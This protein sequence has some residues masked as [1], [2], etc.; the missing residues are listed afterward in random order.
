MY[1]LKNYSRDPT[2]SPMAQSVSFLQIPT[3]Y[4]TSTSNWP[5]IIALTSSHI[6]LYPFSPSSHILMFFEQ[7][8]HTLASRPLEMPSPPTPAPP[9]PPQL[10][11]LIGL[12]S[13][14]P[15]EP[16]SVRPSCPTLV[17]LYLTNLLYFFQ[18]TLSFSLRGGGEELD[19]SLARPYTHCW[20][21]KYL[22][23]VHTKNC[24][25]YSPIRTLFFFSQVPLSLLLDT[26]IWVLIASHHD[27][28]QNLL[29]GFHPLPFFP[30]IYLGYWGLRRANPWCPCSSPKLQTTEVKRGYTGSW[31][32]KHQ[33]VEDTA[34]GS[35]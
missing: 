8:E 18:R 17:P 31:K 12:L 13:F 3:C 5:L 19:V 24:S 4:N 11:W 27:D 6:G 14:P 32:P 2:T 15:Q 23:N 35:S 34:W 28:W 7:A 26:L 25:V 21:H 16:F 20:L 10:L 9:P 30:P 29:T 33:S 1:L 22:L